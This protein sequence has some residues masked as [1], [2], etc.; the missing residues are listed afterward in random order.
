MMRQCVILCF[1]LLTLEESESLAKQKPSKGH[2]AAVSFGKATNGGGFG[3]N[4][5]IISDKQLYIP[6]ESASTKNLIDFLISE[7]CEGVEMDGG[8]A[9][10]FSS[11][12]GLRGLY[13]KESFH[14]GDFLCAIPFTSALVMEEEENV[15]LADAQRGMNFIRKVMDDPEIVAKWGP[16]LESLPKKTSNF[17]PTPDFYTINEIRQLEFPRIVN[18][19]LKRKEQLEAFSSAESVDL[20]ELQ[21][22]TWLIKSRAFSVLKVNREIGKVFTKS[23]LIPYVDMINHSPDQSNVKLEVVETK[24]EDESFY[25][26]CATRPIPAGKEVTLSYGS[27]EASTIELLL[28]YGFVPPKNPNDA[29]MLEFGGVDC[30]TVIDQWSTALKEDEILTRNATGN[31][32]TVLAFRKRLKQALSEIT[33]IR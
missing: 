2:N 22:A 1:L 11:K 10:G 4:K 9:I 18:E 16:Y 32:V 31:L 26:L 14:K 5:P 13:A 8:L 23:V 25:S 17:D 28:N 12:T 30:L 20:D 7:E 24:A 21:F 27:G 15:S 6:D 29:S 33:N 19:A 3:I